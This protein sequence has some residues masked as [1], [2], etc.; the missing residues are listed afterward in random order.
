M[1]LCQISPGWKE[2]GEVEDELLHLALDVHG[3]T[4]PLGLA[5]VEHEGDT[6][7]GCSFHY[8]DQFDK[9]FFVHLCRM[10]GLNMRAMVTAPQ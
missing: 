6:G 9:Y 10:M 7:E 5:D 3:G 4:L 1:N 2:E 8:N